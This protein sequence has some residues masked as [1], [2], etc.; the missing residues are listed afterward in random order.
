[1]SQRNKKCEAC[2]Y[3]LRGAKRDRK[4]TRLNSSHGYISYAVF[5]LKKKEWVTVT[6]LDGLVLARSAF[7]H[8]MNYRS[9]V[10]FGRAAEV[11]DR[12][13]TLRVL[14]AL[15]EHVCRWRSA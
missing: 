14:T 8:S 12:V 13:E 4:S 3:D 7:H 9:V 15:G 1:M 2:S 5:C 10:V 6:L 11:V